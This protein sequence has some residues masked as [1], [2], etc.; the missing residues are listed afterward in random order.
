MAH[1]MLLYLYVNICRY[2]KEC[3]EGTFQGIQSN[4]WS[5]QDNSSEGKNV[6]EHTCIECSA[7]MTYT[8]SVCKYAF[9]PSTC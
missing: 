8:H 4:L 7:C 5:G 3:A 1:L 9:R 6:H 2:N